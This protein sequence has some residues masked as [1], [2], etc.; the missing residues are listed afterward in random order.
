MH[1]CGFELPNIAKREPH[2]LLATWGLNCILYSGLHISPPY[3]P[4]VLYKLLQLCCCS[5]SGTS[6]IQMIVDRAIAIKSLMTHL[7]QDDLT[8]PTLWNIQLQ[9]QAT[10]SGKSKFV[11]DPSRILT[12]CHTAATV[13]QWKLF[14]TST[15]DVNG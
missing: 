2:E 5:V 9:V 8:L 12:T 13:T 15:V 10:K 6:E 1:S 14:W 4:W 3:A 11:C 7:A